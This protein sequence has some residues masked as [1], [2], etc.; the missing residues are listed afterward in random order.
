M[1]QERSEVSEDD[2]CVALRGRDY[3]STGGRDAPDDGP[4]P[5]K[6]RYDL[7]FLTLSTSPKLNSSGVDGID[8][9]TAA[10]SA[11]LS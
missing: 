5:P 3:A 10:V 4:R 1:R 2:E 9:H 11:S 6:D 8:H 7:F